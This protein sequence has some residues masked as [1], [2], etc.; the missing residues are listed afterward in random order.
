M[1][2]RLLLSA[3]FCMFLLAAQ[4]QTATW[5]G[6][7]RV[8][9]APFPTCI[10]FEISDWLLFSS[11]NTSSEPTPISKQ[12]AEAAHDPFCSQLPIL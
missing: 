3:F 5:N 9:I 8:M 6:N 2:L 4:S 10:S 12:A 7:L 1:K 11:G